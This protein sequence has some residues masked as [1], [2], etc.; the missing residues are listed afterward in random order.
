MNHPY[1]AIGQDVNY[2]DADKKIQKGKIT[3]IVNADVAR[4]E[5][6]KHSAVAPHSDKKEP[7]TFHFPTVEAAAPAAGKAGGTPATAEK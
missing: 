7:G 3:E 4:I 2:V 5:W 6:D 1:L